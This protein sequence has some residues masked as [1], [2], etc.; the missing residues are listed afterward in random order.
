MEAVSPHGYE[1][2]GVLGHLGMTRTLG[3]DNERDAG[4]CAN[5]GLLVPHVLATRM[6]SKVRDTRAGQALRP[7]RK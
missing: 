1:A 3:F 2:K 7:G 6:T 4:Q 5:N